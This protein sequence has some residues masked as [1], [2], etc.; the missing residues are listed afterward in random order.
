M[1]RHYLIVASTISYFIICMDLPH[2]SIK[3]YLSVIN[4]DE[5][6]SQNAL[7]FS[8]T[9]FRQMEQTLMKHENR[10]L[11]LENKNKIEDPQSEYSVS[12]N[13]KKYF[14]GNRSQRLQ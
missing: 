13:N 9:K 5:I 12:K 7:N 10:I 4:V 6:F 8:D 14:F 3:Y 1:V 2:A 11:E